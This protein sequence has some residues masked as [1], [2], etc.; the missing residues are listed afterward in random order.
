M[1]VQFRDGTSWT[2]KYLK[3][4][5]EVIILLPFSQCG[6]TMDVVATIYRQGKE[7]GTRIYTKFFSR[8]GKA[9]HAMEVG[10]DNIGVFD[11][12]LFA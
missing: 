11:G 12:S 6:G 3:D 1:N 8:D 5:K 7:R 9:G 2:F 10:Q 4:T